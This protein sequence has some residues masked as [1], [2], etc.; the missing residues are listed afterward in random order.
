MNIPSPIQEIKDTRLKKSQLRLFIKREDLIHPTIS[1]NKW[2]KLK[3]NLQQAKAQKHT[4][5]LTFGGAF[6]NHIYAVAA[7]GKVFNFQTIGIIRGERMNPLNPTLQFAL[8]QGM[9]LAFVSRTEYR[10]KMDP[11]YL[12]SLHKK[13]GTFYPIPEGGTNVYA[14]QGCAEIAEE[15]SQQMSPSPDYICTCCGTGGTMSGIIQGTDRSSHILG[16]AALKGNFLSKEIANLLAMNKVVSAT[17]WSIINDYHFGG[18]A[19][20]NSILIDFINQFKQ[21]HQIPL[22]PIY[23]GKMM[24]GIFD[25]IEQGYFPDG[26][27]IVGI[28]TGGL[29]GIVGFNQRFGN[30]IE[31]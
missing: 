14:L 10:Q 6:S 5:L 24:Y 9:E 19:K 26:S 1:G 12:Q 2:R 7:A 16:F 27:T 17:N 4:T 25:L 3:Y 29:Q 15:I 18:Y 28:H 13:W 31:D 11:S 30:L 23:T 20:F 22:D 8:D 21:Q